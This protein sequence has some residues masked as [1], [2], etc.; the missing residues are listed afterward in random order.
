MCVSG[1]FLLSSHCT[2]VQSGL[3]CPGTRQ[4]LQVFRSAHHTSRHRLRHRELGRVAVLPQF[5]EPAVHV[6]AKYIVLYTVVTKVP[7]TSVT[8]AELPGAQATIRF[9]QEAARHP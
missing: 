7:L 6:I 4:P 8:S 3:G 2:F 1:P 5:L 9:V